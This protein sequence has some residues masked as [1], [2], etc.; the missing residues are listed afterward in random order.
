MTQHWVGLTQRVD[1]FLD[2]LNR[3]THLFS[4][5]L[6]TCQIVR[7]ELM[8]RRI[9][10]TN[11][12]RMTVHSLQDAIEVLLLIRKK[13]GERLLATFLRT[14]KNHLTHGLDLLILKE[15]MLS[16]AQTDTYCTKVTC[17]LCIMRRI[18]IGTNYQLGIFIAKVHQLSKVACHLC[19]LGLHLPVINLTC[20]TIQRNEITLVKQHS[21]DFYSTGLI[22]YID[23]AS[24]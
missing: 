7:N 18:S 2:F 23:C 24:T 4:H 3:D 17:H 16:T 15:H 14:R 22:V 9:E 8:Q 20:R 10:Q 13:L 6:L 11:V 12:Y 19:R 21:V 1:T 5:R